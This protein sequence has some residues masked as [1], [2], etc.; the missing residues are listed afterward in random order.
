MRTYKRKTNWLNTTG[1]TDGSL[2]SMNN[3]NTIPGNSI[4]MNNTSQPLLAQ[5]LDR[6]DYPI[7]EEVLIEP[8]QDYLF[9]GAYSVN[10][11]PV[12][13]PG[14]QYT[15]YPSW[16]SRAYIPTSGSV[17]SPST[18]LN[19]AGS[20]TTYNTDWIR[21]DYETMTGSGFN[22]NGASDP[23]WVRRD[24]ETMAGSGYNPG[25]VEPN[26]VSIPDSELFTEESNGTTSIIGSTNWI[27]E[28]IG[29]MEKELGNLVAGTP[30]YEN[31]KY[32]IST[33]KNTLN[34]DTT[35]NNNDI[36]TNPIEEPAERFQFFN[37]YGGMDL[38]AA[39]YMF[40]NDIKSGNTGPAIFSGLRLGA[41][42]ARN[43]LSG[44]G[45]AN[46]D[47]QVANSYAEQQRDALTQANRPQYLQEGGE[48][49]DPVQEVAQI[50]SEGI[51]PEEVV[52]M[53]VENGVPQEQAI[54]LVEQ[55]SQMFKFGGMLKSKKVK[56][57]KLNEKTGNYEV[58]FE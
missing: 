56:S 35:N 9:E 6:D 12:F 45:N 18:D 14:G 31:L 50:L 37:P 7:T 32:Q 52:Q 46:R 3:N 19:T 29:E 42:L 47:R 58:E 54:A 24:Y 23:D 44:M 21:R 8:G 17:F 5:G 33:Y 27:N 28:Q 48:V 26:T 41:G 2:T 4:T 34:P 20:A 49:N 53:L 39:S 30:E 36:K 16:I 38:G 15:S 22:L 43:F 25:V 1:Y 55:A 51:P 40:G 57:Y 10:E 11:K 13:Q